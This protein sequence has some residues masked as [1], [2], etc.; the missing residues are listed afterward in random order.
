MM[1][2]TE[3][4]RAINLFSCS[5]PED[6]VWQNE[7]EKHLSALKRQGHISVWHK[8]SLLAGTEWKAE[9]DVHLNNADVILLLVSPDFLASEYCF[10]IVM[11]RALARHRAGE[12]RVIPIILRPSLWEQTPLG[13]L[14][15]L[16]TGGEA[17]AQWSNRD[18]AFCNVARGLLEVV[19]SL[20]ASPPGSRA[21][22]VVG[23]LTLNL[24]SVTVATDE[25]KAPMLNNTINQKEVIRLFR[26]LMLPDSQQRILPLIG[27]G[28]MG[29]SHLLTKVFLPL[30]REIYQT[31][32][33]VFDLRN[34][35]YTVPRL[36][37]LACQ[38]L[39]Q[40]DQDHAIW[41][42]LIS[43]YADG[44]DADLSFRF[45]KALSTLEKPVLLVVDSVEQAEGDIRAWLIDVFLMQLAWL[46][47]ARVVIA[48]RSLPEPHGSYA[49]LCYPP[50]FLRQVDDVDAYR[51]YC[52]YQQ[53]WV[54]E[55][56]IW[57]LA[58]ALDFVPGRFAQLIQEKYIAQ[59]VLHG[60]SIAS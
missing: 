7:L 5:A 3:P 36:L 37:S 43:N 49:A 29:K 18:K 6:E 40:Q 17:V 26:H 56:S 23:S 27:E 11:Q 35:M 57:D 44:S 8:H 25:Q 15:V 30:A 9:S 47:Q 31:Y 34:P 51:A 59:R 28:N 14:T 42:N 39:A 52:Q 21:S 60:R 50:C 46:N 2:D 33:V 10:S 48:G 38:Q 1:S 24:S 20:H 58:Y 22:E 54:R 16:P 19:S 32:G 41:R 13:G 53:A 55:E 4:A 45:V 12:A